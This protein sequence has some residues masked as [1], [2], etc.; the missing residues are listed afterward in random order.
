[1][2]KFLKMRKYSHEEFVNIVSK[3]SEEEI[4][5]FSSK[6]GGYPVLFRMSLD[7][8]IKHI[9]FIQPGSAVI[10]VDKDGKILVQERADNGR[11]SFPG[12]C[13]EI[14]ETLEDTAIRELFEETGIK[15]SKDDLGF[16]AN[17]SGKTRR[18]IY[19]NGDIVYNNT[20]LFCVYVSD[21][22]KKCLKANEESKSLKFVDLYEVPD[23]FMDRDL[24]DEYIKYISK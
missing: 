13:Q 11:Y 5:E 18:N 14:S 2:K 20:T 21:N 8:K 17:I 1:M 7:E 3:M 9:P 19:L 24:I 22:D 4:I 15:V 23:N 16:I 10:C 6:Y 12:G